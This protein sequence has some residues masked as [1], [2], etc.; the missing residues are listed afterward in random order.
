MSSPSFLSDFS[1]RIR[2]RAI[3]PSLLAL[4]SQS[5]NAINRML[6]H[7]TLKEEISA[8]YARQSEGIPHIPS[9]LINTVYAHL[10][11]QQYELFNK[12]NEFKQDTRMEPTDA[13][14]RKIQQ[15]SAQHSLDERIELPFYEHVP[16]SSTINTGKKV[17]SAKE[18]AN[19]GV[20]LN[21]DH[22]NLA[23]AIQDLR[24]PSAWDVRSKCDYIDTSSDYLQL[25]YTGKLI[26]PNSIA[27]YIEIMSFL[28]DG[29]DGAEV[30]SVRANHAMRRQCG[31]YY[32]E[33]QVIS[34]GIDGHIGIGFCRKINSLN[35]FPG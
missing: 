7:K 16:T 11:K 4:N 25:T 26:K 14:R 2:N 5:R 22:H 17:P 30:A 33:V 34:K 21:R 10:V 23:L 6:K 3:N 35:R 27:G 31:I 13:V 9:Y 12:R 24:L 1:P 8:F 32:F 28:G 18:Y 20:L 29:K 19:L 15:N